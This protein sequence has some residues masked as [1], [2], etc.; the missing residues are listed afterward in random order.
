M[1][2]IDDNKSVPESRFREIEWLT[3]QSLPFLS[4]HVG[5]LACVIISSLLTLLDP[6]IMK[7]LIDDVLPRQDKK[8]L[9][10]AT[11]VFLLTYIGRLAFISISCM[12]AF[13]AAQKMI[14][15]IR[16]KLLRHLQRLS[17]EHHDNASVGDTM[18]RLDQDVSQVGELG[19]D[20]IPIC[21]RMSLVASMVLVMMLSLNP[22]LTCVILPLIPL[23]LFVHWL[24]RAR[25]RKCSDEVQGTL[26]KLCN[27]LQEHLF[28]IVQVQLLR[29]ETAEARRFVGLAGGS[30]RAQVRRRMNEI[31]FN[32][33]S[34]SIIVIG[35]TVILGYGGYQVLSGALSI[36]GLVAFYSYVVRLF[37]PLGGA[38][39]VSSKLHRAGASIRRILEI[40]RSSV[41]I[42]DHPCAKEVPRNILSTVEFKDVCFEYQPGSPVLKS[43][44]LEV[45]LGERVALVGASGSGKSTIA[46]LIVRLYDVKDGMISIGGMNIRDLT[47]NCLRSSIA[48]MTQDLI[49]F[50]TTLRENIL[51][52]R[53]TATQKEVLEA[54]EQAQLQKLIRRLPNGLDEPIGPRGS[55]LSGGERQRVV[56][57]RT[58]LQNPFIL[59]LDEPTSA[60]DARIERAFWESLDQIT[61]GKTTIVISHSLSTILKADRIAVLDDGRIVEEGTHNQLIQRNKFYC[62][63]Y[64]EQ[65][66]ANSLKSMLRSR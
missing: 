38:V 42:K 29:R 52:G 61:R 14:F 4:L 18:H 64:E 25:L 56:L 34:L 2:R 33:M 45:N 48:L 23:F 36:G 8:W 5:S 54:A 27:F 13:L 3:A 65:L 55:K 46:K 58:M 51:Y 43:I 66:K 50:D 32:L 60:L 24:Y 49:L 17:P 26:G 35:I 47:L 7:W 16:L 44:N 39:D 30:A 62:E 41:L 63:L 57:A 53:P 59:L 12:L 40:E 15:R 22:R 19:G 21:L 11:S 31:V 1:G 10:I 20:F 37:E 28:S 9:F 6:L